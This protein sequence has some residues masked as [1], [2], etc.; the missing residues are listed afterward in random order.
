[1]LLAEVTASDVIIR[2]HVDDLLS[3][4]G[5]PHAISGSLLSGYGVTVPAG[6]LS[7]ARELMGR[8]P[9]VISRKTLERTEWE[10]RGVIRFGDVRGALEDQRN[11]I[12][13]PCSVAESVGRLRRMGRALVAD[14]V[15]EVA[16]AY[17][18]TDSEVQG[19]RELPR[20]LRQGGEVLR[21]ADVSCAFNTANGV[22]L[23]WMGQGW[24]TPGGLVLMETTAV[25][26]HFR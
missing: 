12:E 16:E 22:G 4:A 8:D 9:I 14:I 15:A 18:M 26:G 19:V 23:R 3:S 13:A 21:A 2:T 11:L 6:A 7:K 17:S 24:R 1:V 10:P 25:L 20:S 5:V